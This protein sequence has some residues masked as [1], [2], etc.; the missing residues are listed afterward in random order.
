MYTHK[1][2]SQGQPPGPTG[3]D[4]SNMVGD[5]IKALS[6]ALVYPDLSNVEANKRLWNQ[7]AAQWSPQSEFVTTMARHTAQTEKKRDKGDDHESQHPPGL[8]ASDAVDVLGDEWSSQEDLKE[9][10]AEFILPYL[11]DNRDKIVCEVGVGGGRVAAKVLP[12][13]ASLT[14]MDVSSGMLQKAKEALLKGNNGH[15]KLD[16]VLIDAGTLS[17][18]AN[19]EV[20]K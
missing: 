13:V 4:G 2:Y 15:G 14:C 19:L 7:Y 6:G 17:Y 5:L 8:Q 3:K 12:H 18:P 10:V 9:V 16:F 11:T 1:I 20:K